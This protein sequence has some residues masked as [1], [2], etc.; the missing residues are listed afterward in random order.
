[1]LAMFPEGTRHRDPDA[2]RAPRGARPAR[3]RGPGADRPVRDHR[4]REA[5]HRRLLPRAGQV[6]VAFA[7][8]ISP[9]ELEATPQ[10]AAELIQEQ[11]WPEVEQQYRRLRAN[12]GL[13]AA[14]IAALSAGTGVAIRAQTKPKTRRQKVVA[15]LPKPRR[16]KKKGPLKR[17]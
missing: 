1:M 3:D 4:H 2:L 13:I 16:K 15:A 8:A 6:Q 5:L 11:V 7:P 10:A 9:A 14:V 12:P 17:R